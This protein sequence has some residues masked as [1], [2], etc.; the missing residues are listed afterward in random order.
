MHPTLILTMF[1][2]FWLAFAVVKE[3]ADQEHSYSASKSRDEDCISTALHKVRYCMTYELRAVKWRRSLISAAL[4]TFALFAVCWRRIP[5]P[6]E[7]LTHMLFI[8]MVFSVVW[9]NFSSVTGTDALKYCD[10]N[11][12]HIKKLLKKNRSFILPS[13]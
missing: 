9:G 13:W 2:L 12:D 1:L 3:K 10:D 7:I 6:A 11:M 4:A 8:T 5:T